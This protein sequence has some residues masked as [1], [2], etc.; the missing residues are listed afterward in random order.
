MRTNN[1][2]IKIGKVVE[3]R[4][5]KTNKNNGDLESVGVMNKF[6]PLFIHDKEE[7]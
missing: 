7:Y 4:R 2:R 1:Y 3:S 6:Q 5:N